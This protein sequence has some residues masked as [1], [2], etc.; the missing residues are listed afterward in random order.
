MCKLACINYIS[1]LRSLRSRPL[2]LYKQKKRE[3]IK[4]LFGTRNRGRTGTGITA[5]RILSPACLPI[6]PSEPHNL[7]KDGAKVQFYFYITKHSP[8]NL[9]I[10][11]GT[12]PLSQS[13]DPISDQKKP[14]RYPP[15]LPQFLVRR[16]ADVFSIKKLPQMGHTWR[17]SHLGQ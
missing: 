1:S 3:A 12:Y 8:P 5:H 9:E 10:I 6:P 14:Q 4:L 11:C 13:Q 2:A 7:R 16:V 15:A 17:I